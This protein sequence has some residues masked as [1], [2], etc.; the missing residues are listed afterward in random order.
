M[1][2]RNDAPW[3]A[4]AIGWEGSACGERVC[5]CMYYAGGNCFRHPLEAHCVAE[6]REDQQRVIFR[7]RDKHW[8]LTCGDKMPR[9]L[10]HIDKSDIVNVRYGNYK[11][12]VI[13]EDVPHKHLSGLSWC[14]IT[15]YQILK[16]PTEVEY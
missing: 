7:R 16:P 6:L 5:E 14:A 11:R 9:A 13:M 10:L 1:V 3:E 12:V 4:I 8:K 15:A 2:N